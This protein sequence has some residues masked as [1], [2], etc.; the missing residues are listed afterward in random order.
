[1][2]SLYEPLTNNTVLSREE[3]ID[4]IKY[5]L[6]QSLQHRSNY[7]RLRHLF[8]L[9][10]TMVKAYHKLEYY[11]SKIFKYCFY[12]LINSKKFRNAKLLGEAY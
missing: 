12:S 10:L 2:T 5:L 4:I 8:E 6:D 7:N 3:K 11:D 1:M 9:H